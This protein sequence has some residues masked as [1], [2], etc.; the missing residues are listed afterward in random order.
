MPSRLVTI[1][2]VITWFACLVP[3]GQL[4]Y[5]TVTNHLGP[6]PVAE[7]THQTGF[8]ALRFLLLCLAVTPVRRLSAHLAWLIRFRKMF[9]NYSFFYACLHLLTYI[10]LYSAFSWPA[11]YA[12]VLKR[13]FITVGFAAWLLML[14][15]ALTSTAWAIRTLGGKRWQMLHRLVYAS[16]ILAIIH[17]WWIVKPGVRTPMAATIVLA[18]LLLARVVWSVLRLRKVSSGVAAA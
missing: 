10:W 6:D 9:G 7:V 2:K 18:V 4:I 16:A 17:Y 8:W 14:P 12:D 1:L 11:M 5:R 15:L 13:R 3:L